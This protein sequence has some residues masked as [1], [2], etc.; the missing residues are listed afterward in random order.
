MEEVVQ[1]VGLLDK[2]NVKIEK[3]SFSEKRRLHIGRVMIHNPDLVILEEP[4]QNVDTE[5]TIIIRKAIMK[6]KEQGKAILLRHLFY[7]MR[8]R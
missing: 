1:Y 7:Q 5:S 6:M 3:L 4:E 8:S 2:L